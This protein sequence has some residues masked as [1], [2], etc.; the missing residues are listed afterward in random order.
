MALGTNTP[1]LIQKT[2]RI[3]NIKSNV[4][5]T[6]NTNKRSIKGNANIKGR[7]SADPKTDTYKT[8]KMTF[9]IKE[10]LIEKLYNFAYWDRRS[11]TEAI[12]IA[13]AEGLKNKPAKQRP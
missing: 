1:K 9:Y 5:N 8:K 10:P 11:V 12:N 2:T 7:P 6:R 3:K 4:S 13:I